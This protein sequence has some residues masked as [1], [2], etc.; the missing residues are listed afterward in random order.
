MH[1]ILQN[2]INIIRSSMGYGFGRFSF[3]IGFIQ[4]YVIGVFVYCYD[5]FVFSDGQNY[6]S[7]NIWIDF[8]FRVYINTFVGI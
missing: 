3:F 6:G 1:P 4:S 2:G 8:I 5:V 7:K